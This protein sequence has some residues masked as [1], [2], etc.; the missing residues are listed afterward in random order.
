[1]PDDLTPPTPDPHANDL[2]F[3]ANG[4]VHMRAS[5]QDDIWHVGSP[6]TW[7]AYRDGITGMERT[8]EHAQR[9]LEHQRNWHHPTEWLAEARKTLR[10][11]KDTA[12]AALKTATGE[13][14][15]LLLGQSQAYSHALDILRERLGNER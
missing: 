1:M 13:P 6:D 3:V 15:M 5:L 4:C 12:D 7:I 9:E 14:R 8:L 10:A 11:A 2:V